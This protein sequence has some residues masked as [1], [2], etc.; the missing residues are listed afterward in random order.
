MKQPT[1]HGLTVRTQLV[2]KIKRMITA[3]KRKKKSP[4]P[5]TAFRGRIEHDCASKILEYVLNEPVEVNQ[6]APTQ[7]AN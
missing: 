5:I 4:D 3:S 7:Q 6:A 2:S 1:P